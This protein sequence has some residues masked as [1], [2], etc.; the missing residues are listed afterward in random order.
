MSSTPL[1]PKRSLEFLLRRAFTKS[2]AIELKFR[3]NGTRFVSTRLKIRNNRRFMQIFNKYSLCQ[4]QKL[5]LLCNFFA[6]IFSTFY[7]ERRA[8]S[9]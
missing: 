3:G 6:V 2:R 8:A 4:R 9:E 7:S 5:L 1:N